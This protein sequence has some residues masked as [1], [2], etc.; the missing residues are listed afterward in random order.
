M[1][2]ERAKYFFSKAISFFFFLNNKIYFI[3]LLLCEIS[4]IIICNLHCTVYTTT[5]LSC[6]VVQL[7]YSSCI[8]NY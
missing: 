4:F 2:T 1:E 5:V 7:L 3:D 6:T 8:H